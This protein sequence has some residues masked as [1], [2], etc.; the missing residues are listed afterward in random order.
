MLYLDYGRKEGEWIANR[1]GG[2]ENLG[3]IDVLKKLAALFHQKEDGAILIA[4]EEMASLGVTDPLEDNGLGFD[5]KWN[6]CW[7]SDFLKYMKLDPLFRKGAG[8]N[9]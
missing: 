4:K 5:L 2:N 1:Y 9:I 6:I 3:G 7:T 8:N